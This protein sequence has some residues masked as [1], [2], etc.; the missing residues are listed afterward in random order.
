MPPD[1]E[2]R[3]RHRLYIRA[4]PQGLDAGPPG[5]ADG[6]ACVGTDLDFYG[7]SSKKRNQPTVEACKAVC[8]SCPVRD[9]CL[10]LAMANREHFGI[11]GGL[12]VEERTALRR[13]RRQ[14]S[15]E[16]EAA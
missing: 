13:R 5:W 15:Q 14:K 2:V 4:V 16:A 10:E 3:P 9:T 12:T 8:A 7:D 1:G 11:W 6:A